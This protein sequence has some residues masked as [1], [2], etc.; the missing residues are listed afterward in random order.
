MNTTI[1]R[2]INSQGRLQ[3]SKDLCDYAGIE[4]ETRVVI[5]KGVNNNEIYII[6]IDKVQDSEEVIAFLK[7][8]S[9]CRV[10]IPTEIKKNDDTFEITATRSMII[11][12]TKSGY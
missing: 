7:V 8:D 1:V 12:R 11:I 6:S 4:K 9:K 3:L 2:K 10:V 5:K